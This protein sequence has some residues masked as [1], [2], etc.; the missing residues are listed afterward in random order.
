MKE[1]KN[2][3]EKSLGEANGGQAS[4]SLKKQGNKNDVYTDIQI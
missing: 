1:A 2:W 4:A 3:N